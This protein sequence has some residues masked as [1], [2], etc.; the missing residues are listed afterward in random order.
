M[1]QDLLFP[2]FVDE[3]IEDKTSGTF[4]DN[5]KLP[6]HRWYR[7]TAGFSAAWV[8]D[9]IEREKRLGRHHVLDPFAG[10][11][12]VPVEGLLHGVD[13]KGVEANPYVYS[14]AEAKLRWID[15]EPDRLEREC[16]AVLDRAQRLTPG[17]EKHPELVEKCFPTET[18]K[19]LDALKLA[20]EDLRDP[21]IK[22]FV[23][24]LI[25]SILRPCSPVGTAQWQYI[26]PRKSKAKV[27]D[28]FDAYRNKV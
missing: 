25:T 24:F 8:G 2:D 20:R 11:G 28:P 13:T 22:D 5:M 12:T 21:D 27:A 1:I 26:Q 19:R 6:V 15:I 7:Y 23:W 4:V 18:L 10:S 17:D 3:S 14:I 16:F 9:L